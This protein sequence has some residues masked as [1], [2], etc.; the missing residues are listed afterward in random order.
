MGK[1]GLLAFMLLLLCVVA[2]TATIPSERVIVAADTTEM[3]T[4]LVERYG[5]VVQQAYT[6]VPAVAAELPAAS[7]AA[8]MAQAGVEVH[9]DLPVDAAGGNNPTVFFPQVVGADQAWEQNIRGR[10]V[11]VAVVDSGISDK[12]SWAENN[13][14][15]R[16]DALDNGPKR[17][18]AYGHGTYLA[19]IIGSRRHDD[20]GYAGVAPRVKFVDVRV[21]DES[22]SGNYTDIVEGLDWILANHEEYDIRIVNMSIVGLVDR[23]YFANIINQAV[24]RLWEAGIVVVAAAGNGGVTES[25]D[26]N[27]PMTISVPGNDP[28]VITVGA[29]TDN[30]TPADMS[31]DYVA[32][33][34]GAGPTEMGFVKPDV[35]AP[36]AHMI[37]QMRN[38]S[39]WAQSGSAEH[40][41][42][43][44]WQSA[45]TSAA[46]AVVTGVAA[47]ILDAN[48]DLTPDQ[49]KYILMAEAAPAVYEDGSLAWSI[50]QQG[51]GRV[52]A[53]SAIAAVDGVDVA[54]IP[55][56]NAG[57]IAGE[58]FAGP[59]VFRDGEFHFV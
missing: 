40:I 38:N 47:L 3:A 36:G 4:V 51:A 31:D 34:S 50:F 58:P 12:F 22:G 52:W 44:W 39:P 55:S 19:G 59:V 27:T 15:A 2:S 32:P 37:S 14:I 46:T 7:L 48:P 54:T 35:I 10:G 9:R 25:S 42:G 41:T 18:D 21:L 8:L 17:Y 45:G 53:P 56:A 16:Y 57:L 13:T 26:G 11:V 24:E 23:P 5:G 43:H 1:K 33:F 29:F 6:I 30:F 28:F 20:N 49:V